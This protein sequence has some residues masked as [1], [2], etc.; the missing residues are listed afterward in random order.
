MTAAYGNGPLRFRAIDHNDGAFTTVHGQRHGTPH[1]Y[2]VIAPWDILGYVYKVEVNVIGATYP[3]WY[4][5]REIGVRVY[6]GFPTRREAAE[7][8]LLPDGNTDTER[9]SR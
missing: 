2:E 9:N 8:L 4:R 3:R 1:R 5:E 7:A 6:G